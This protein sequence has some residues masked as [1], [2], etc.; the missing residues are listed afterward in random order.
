MK[1][2]IEA[3]AVVLAGSGIW[4]F[5][6]TAITNIKKKKNPR[7]DMMLAI[8]RDRLLFLCKCYI[9]KGSIPEDEFES[10]ASLGNAYIRMKGNSTVKKLFEK[11][12]KLPLEIE[13]EDKK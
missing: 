6:E 8:G 9:S 7:D 13:M 4:H 10:F 11:A 3:F 1:E 12:E 5:L 2:L